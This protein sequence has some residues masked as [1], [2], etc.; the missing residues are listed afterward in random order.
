MNLSKVLFFLKTDMTSGKFWLF[1]LPFLCYEPLWSDLIICALLY[2][3][4]VLW[5][6]LPE[7]LDQP[8]GLFSGEFLYHMVLSV[9]LYYIDVALQKLLIVHY[10]SYFYDVDMIIW[11]VFSPFPL[12]YCPFNFKLLI[13]FLDWLSFMEPVCLPPFFLC[14]IWDLSLLPVSPY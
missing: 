10:R 1:W 4:F 14:Y 9:L 12:M 8:G 7:F 3:V 11:S 13:Y 5:V 2:G 6:S